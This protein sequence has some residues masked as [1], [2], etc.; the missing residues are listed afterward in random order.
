MKLKKNKKCV[1]WD[2]FDPQYYVL[3]DNSDPLFW[4]VMG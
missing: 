2:N 1:L 4:I 3:W